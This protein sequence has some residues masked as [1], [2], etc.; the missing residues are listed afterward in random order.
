VVAELYRDAGLELQA[1]LKTLTETADVPFN[2]AAA[3]SMLGHSQPNGDLQMPVLSIHTTY[4]PLVPAE[5]EEEYADDV[6]SQGNRPLFR[7]AFVDRPGHCSFTSAELVAGVKVL[8]ERVDTG[9][10]PA[11]SVNPH[12]LNQLASS[13]GLGDSAFIRFRPAEFIADRSDSV[14]P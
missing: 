5:H 2:E 4:D 8:E 3:E 11:A 14:S 13:F 6:V 12:E 9:R 1:D 7:Q 10:W